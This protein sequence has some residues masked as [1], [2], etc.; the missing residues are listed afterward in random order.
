MAVVLG[1]VYVWRRPAHRALLRKA[2]THAGLPQPVLVD[3]PVAV[4]GHLLTE[5]APIPTDSA[6]LVCDLSVG[7]TEATVVHRN[8]GGFDVQGNIH[9]PH[10]GTASVDEALAGYLATI[11]TRFTTPDTPTSDRVADG[12]AAAAD[13]A[14]RLAAARI[15]RES[16]THAPAVAVP[17]PGL[18]VVVDQ[19][20]LDS[21]AQPVLTQAV[22]TI[23]KASTPRRS[24]RLTWPAATASARPATSPP[25]PPPWP[26]PR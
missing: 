7:G 23:Q 15:A 20:T 16:L 8:P 3:T 18:P 1:G 5:G 26:P 10:A 24:P 22:T 14:A 13:P 6:I 21:L 2:A 11:A 19:P 4:A 9:S 25:P 17:G 12:S